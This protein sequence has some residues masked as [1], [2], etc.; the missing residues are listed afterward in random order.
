[1]FPTGFPLPLLTVI[2]FSSDED[3]RKYLESLQRKSEPPLQVAEV[4]SCVPRTPER[5]GITVED[6]P[7]GKDFL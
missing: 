4:D 7:D 1:M 5:F 2:I 6:D 3:V